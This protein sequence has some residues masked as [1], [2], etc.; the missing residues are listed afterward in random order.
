LDLALAHQH[1][2][3]QRSQLWRAGQLG[4]ALNGNLGMMAL[5]ESGARNEQR[6]GSNAKSR[7]DRHKSPHSGGS[8]SMRGL[9]SAHI[10]APGDLWLLPALR[11]GGRKGAALYMK[12]L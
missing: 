7:G 4:A 1:V 10:L 6:Q 3:P 5:R 2:G 12:L 8:A 11:R 9:A